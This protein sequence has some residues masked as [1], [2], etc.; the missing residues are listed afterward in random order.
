MSSAACRAMFTIAADLAASRGRSLTADVVAR[1]RASTPVAI[2]VA[3]EVPDITPHRLPKIVD[4]TPTPGAVSAT[5]APRL[6]KLA[7][8]LCCPPSALPR[9]ALSVQSR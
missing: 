5:F 6:E 7:R 1:R 8:K 2:G 9:E 3:M 4:T